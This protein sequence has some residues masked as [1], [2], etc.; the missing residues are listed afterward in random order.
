MFYEIICYDDKSVRQG[1]KMTK[2]RIFLKQFSNVY[3]V[4]SL[5]KGDL[6]CI[7]ELCKTNPYYY[8][9]CPPNPTFETIKQDMVA[10]PPRTTK[11]DKRY[12]G[13][14]SENEL[15][16]VLDLI[17]NYP[18]SESC[19]IGFFM[20]HKKYQG[21]GIGS[22]IVQNVLEY[23]KEFY[24]TVHLG[25]VSTNEQAKR[26]WLK[27]GFG[28]TGKEYRQPLYLVKIMAKTLK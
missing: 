8:Q 20:M 14:F 5:T 21:Q 17:L 9:H 1:N 10:L 11:K 15:I 23:L 27:N 3:Q 16:A 25:Y 26:F 6:S 28:N 12:V 19:F 22:Q 24:K 4:R 7:L 2:R 18:N 13:F